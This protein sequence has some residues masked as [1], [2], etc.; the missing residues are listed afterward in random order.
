MANRYTTEVT[1]L[2][3]VIKAIALR[4]LPVHSATD[5]DVYDNWNSPKKLKYGSVNI[6]LDSVSYRGQHTVYRFILYYGDRLLQDKSNANQ[7]YADALNVLQ[8]V[9][10]ALNTINGVDIEGPTTYTPFEQQFMDYLAGLYVTVDILVESILGTCPNLMSENGNWTLGDMMPGTMGGGGDDRPEPDSLRIQS[11]TGTS[12]ITVVRKPAYHTLYATYDKG[13]SWREVEEGDVLPVM[14]GGTMWMRGT[15]EIPADP[16]EEGGLQFSI[17]GYVHLSGYVHMLFK[18]NGSTS[19]YDFP[20]AYAH[21]F[22][23]CE[24]IVS[25]SGLQAIVMNQVGHAKDMFSGCVNLQRPPF[26]LFPRNVRLTRSAICQGMFKDCASLISSPQF[27]IG[28]TAPEY[29][30]AHAFENCVSIL[31]AHGLDARYAKSHA[32]DSMYKGCTSIKYGPYI[33]AKYPEPFAFKDAF[34]GCSSLEY[35]VCMSESETDGTFSGWMD[36]VAENGVFYKSPDAS[37]WSVGPNGIPSNWDV[38]EY[39]E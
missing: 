15:C 2:I 29:M 28:D 25:C 16:Q 11:M 31:N 38:Q 27:S 4:Q 9:V 14:E 12:N 13:N 3:K 22:E 34:N 6:G 7:I 26:V 20:Y 35:I 19:N 5:G 24:G 37:F 21:M 10:N 18:H 17:D 8:S 39:E 33:G 32:F 23:N 30:F 1:G 36:G